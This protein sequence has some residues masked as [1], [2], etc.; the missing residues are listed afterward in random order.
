MI[1]N[2]RAQATE[3]KIQH[4]IERIKKAGYQ[5]HVTRG[6]ERAIVAAVVEVGDGTNWKR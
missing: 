4:V 1:I 3:Q 2:M 6:E 5:A